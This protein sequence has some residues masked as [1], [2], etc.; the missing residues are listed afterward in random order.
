MLVA[1]SKETYCR[2]VPQI[3]LHGAIRTYP[4]AI[5]ILFMLHAVH[6]F[7][8][9]AVDTFAYLF[10]MLPSQGAY[11][12][13]HCKVSNV[14]TDSTVAGITSPR[15]VIGLSSHS[16]VDNCL[17]SIVRGIEISATACWI[18]DT[19]LCSVLS[20]VLVLLFDIE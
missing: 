3:S 9:E 19:A 20:V 8:L 14:S 15:Y 6:F 17:Y 7:D 18:F 10:H 12:T 1:A 4:E 5:K 13:L 11:Q 16:I 2:Q